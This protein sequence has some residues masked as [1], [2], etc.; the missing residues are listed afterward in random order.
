MAPSREELLVWLG[1]IHQD[2][3]ALGMLSPVRQ[4]PAET[5]VAW[6]SACRAF[7]P[8]L[9]A[10]LDGED[11]LALVQALLDLIE[12]PTLVLRQHCPD[13][14]TQHKPRAGSG[15]AGTAAVASRSALPSRSGTPGPAR[16]RT[17]DKR[18]DRATALVYKDLA[19]KAMQEVLSNGCAGHTRATCDI[20]RG[21]HPPGKGTAGHSPTGPQ[22]KVTPKQAQRHLFV[23][24]GKKRVSEDC[25]GWSASLLFPLRG[26]K[27]R[28]RYIPFIHQVARLVA[29]IASAEVPA[30][31]AHILTCGDLVALHKLDATQQAE[32]AAANKP[33]ALRPVNKGCNILKYRHLIA[34]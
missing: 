18:L 22:V 16:R 31:F 12:L 4:W 17:G 8:R 3:R 7:T 10:A 33:P 32:V 23:A 11:N 1:A 27:K 20:L 29:R 13:Q 19:D 21:M 15:E 6:T 24:A 34:R 26:Q 9:A 28:G 5:L 25:F 30:V 14:R 2:S